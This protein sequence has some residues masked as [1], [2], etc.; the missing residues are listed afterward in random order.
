VYVSFVV[1]HFIEPFISAL[2][3]DENVG[4]GRIKKLF[5]FR[6]DHDHQHYLNLN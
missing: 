3:Y 5:I 1:V 2:E 6:T 4:V